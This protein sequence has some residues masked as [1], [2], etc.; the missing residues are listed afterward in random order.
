MSGPGRI[1]GVLET[2][3]VSAASLP[4]PSGAATSSNQTTANT[5]LAN[6]DTNTSKD[7]STFTF[8]SASLSAVATITPASGKSIKIYKVLVTNSS[9]NATFRNVTLA[10]VSLGTFLQGEAIASS[11]NITLALNE[12]LTIT[13]A[14]GTVYVNIQYKEI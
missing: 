3:P 7:A 2:Q 12:S 1:D 13:P 5:S 10:S 9:N 11:W 6:I 4:L 8:Y 14:G